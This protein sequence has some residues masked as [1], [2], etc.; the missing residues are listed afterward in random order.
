ML[1]YEGATFKRS[2]IYL[3][4]AVICF[5]VVRFVKFSPQAPSP[6]DVAGPPIADLLLGLIGIVAFVFAIMDAS[7]V[8]DLRLFKKTIECDQGNLYLTRKD[9]ETTI[10][11]SAITSLRLSL[12]GFNSRNV[13]G[14]YWIY[15]IDY[16]DMSGKSKQTEITVYNKMSGHFELF[17]KRLKEKNPSV[18]IK[19][20]ATSLDWVVRLFKKKK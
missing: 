8:L 20:W 10:P 12:T 3:W 16:T 15:L 7:F 9:Q 5:L 6:G 19:N 2:R 14:A 17:E 18:E 13:R 1:T 11:F 4:I